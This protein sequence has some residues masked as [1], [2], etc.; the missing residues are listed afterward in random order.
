MK[1]TTPTTIF[2]RF[3]DLCG[4]SLGVSTS[5]DLGCTYLAGGILFGV[6]KVE[7]LK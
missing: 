7:K 5:C 6:I 4:E 3:E 1:I 2:M